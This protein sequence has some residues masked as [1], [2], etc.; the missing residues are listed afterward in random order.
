M[1]TF[2]LKFVDEASIYVDEFGKVRV[3][4]PVGTDH[5]GVYNFP[6]NGKVRS[7]ILLTS[8]SDPR[9]HLYYEFVEGTTTARTFRN[10]L[11]RAAQAGWIGANDNVIMDN[12]R[13]HNGGNV[14]ADVDRVLELVG[15]RRVNL[16]AYS[17][18]LNPCEFVFGEMKHYLRTHA[19][20]GQFTAHRIAEAL[21]NIPR[22]HIIATYLHCTS[23]AFRE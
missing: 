20:N 1:Y 13:V 9:G 19:A 21:Q 5:Y 23:I 17:P 6:R 4:G 7:I 3:A 22:S 18:E 15:A 14:L 12:A 11:A 2:Q 16:P 10:F 8:L